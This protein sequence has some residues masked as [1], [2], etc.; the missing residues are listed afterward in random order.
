[1]ARLNRNRSTGAPAPAAPAPLPQRRLAALIKDWAR[2]HSG[3]SFFMTSHQKEMFRFFDPFK[4]EPKLS[5]GAAL[6]KPRFR[7]AK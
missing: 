6:I 7:M 4:E 5:K 2:Q 1:M 3:L